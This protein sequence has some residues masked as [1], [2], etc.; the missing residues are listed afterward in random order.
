MHAQVALSN[1][2]DEHG[3]AQKPIIAEDYIWHMLKVNNGDRMAIRYSVTEN[4]DFFLFC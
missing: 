2:C 4:M 3:K 1:F